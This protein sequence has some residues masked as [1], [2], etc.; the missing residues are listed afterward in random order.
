MAFKVSP[1]HM[2]MNGSPFLKNKKEKV[3]AQEHEVLHARVPYPKKSSKKPEKIY[4]NEGDKTIYN[5]DGSVS[6]KQTIKPASNETAKPASNKTAPTLKKGQSKKEPKRVKIESAGKA[7]QGTTEYIRGGR[8]GDKNARNVEIGRDYGNDQRKTVRR[9][10]K[11]G[12]IKT[13]SKKISDKKAARIKKRK[14]K[15]HT[16]VAKMVSPLNDTP[17]STTKKHNT[18]NP[19]ALKSHIKSKHANDE[20]EVESDAGKNQVQTQLTGMTKA[21]NKKTAKAGAKNYDLT[22]YADKK[23][24]QK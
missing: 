2:E 22:R 9:K 6:G 7:N 4:S 24:K 13:T 16:A 8:D 15:N 11:D 18:Y 12:S 17:G 23:M 14:E 10:K 21:K 1:F 3:T 19:Q 5:K 20:K